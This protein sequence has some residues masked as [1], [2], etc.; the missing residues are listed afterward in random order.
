MKKIA[1]F[2]MISSAPFVLAACQQKADEEAS[3]A[4]ETSFEA[5]PAPVEVA[6]AA[7]ADTSAVVP[8]DAASSAPTDAAAAAPAEAP[9]GDPAQM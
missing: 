5:A 4:A 3:P 9:A 1:L 6:P 2:L 8:A 7:A